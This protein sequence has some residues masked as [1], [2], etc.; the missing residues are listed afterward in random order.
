MDDATGLCVGCGRTRDEIASWGQMAEGKREWVWGELAA[1]R[2][3]LNLSLHRLPWTH[4]DLRR[5]VVQ[6]FRLPGATWVSGVSGALAEFCFDAGERVNLDIE[7]HRIVART[8][9]AAI[10]ID[11]NE[12]IRA[13]A[14]GTGRSAAERST[15]LLVLPREHVEGRPPEG[16]LRVGPDREALVR[17]ACDET[18]Y[19]FGLGRS[20]GHFG[21]RTS[22]SAL[23]AC[24][25]SAIGLPWRDALAA[26][27]SALVQASPTRVVRNPIGR[28][29]VSTR[30]PP[31]GGKTP[32]G[33]HT[34][35]L[36]PLI[37]T[38][39]DIPPA[40]SLPS[41]LVPCLTYYPAG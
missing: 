34:H 19:D 30:I 18:L 27:G 14:L 25:D 13:V 35:F 26:T 17:E 10:C 2:A 6:S 21:I 16:F 4:E 32:P 28:I 24:L 31:P 1:R 37:D 41:N 15:V 22:S 11:L 33:P 7:A 36:P 12:H 8:S 38:A 40:V 5:F 39:N 20:A 29:E 23:Q 9:R 3:T